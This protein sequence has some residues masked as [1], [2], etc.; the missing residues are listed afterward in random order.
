MQPRSLPTYRYT[1]TRCY[2]TNSYIGKSV[3]LLL[4]QTTYTLNITETPF[5]CLN[6]RSNSYIYHRCYKCTIFVR[7]RKRTGI[8]KGHTI[9]SKNQSDTWVRHED[10]KM[11]CVARRGRRIRYEY[12]KRLTVVRPSR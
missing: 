6:Y 8:T 12:F 7:T 4:R 5:V 2:V 9:K 1:S 3:H 10:E 11:L